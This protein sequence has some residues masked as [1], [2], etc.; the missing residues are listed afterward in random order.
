MIK[1]SSAINE[2][3]AD[4]PIMESGFNN[5][6]YNLTALAK[7]IKPMVE[8]R[9][10]KSVNINALLMC[11]SRLQ[12][13]KVKKVG[14]Y[15]TPTVVNVTVHS[16]LCS[17]SY[18]ANRQLFEKINKI[19]TE[20]KKVNGYISIIQG[21]N[22]TTLIIDKQF[23][24]ISDKYITE[25]RKNFQKDIA[26]LNIELDENVYDIPAQFYFLIQAISLQGINIREI[27][28]TFSEVIL[29]L[30]EKDIKLGFDTIYNVFGR[31]K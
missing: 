30:D 17:I 14:L 24:G 18:F 13:K 9:A 21:I 29:Y 2:I 31:N 12:R 16:G 3:F 7:F 23:M 5:K 22:E 8:A 27:T 11:L 25:P 28:S 26:S 1:I 15:K 19:Y 6:L 10:K 4:Q 20:I